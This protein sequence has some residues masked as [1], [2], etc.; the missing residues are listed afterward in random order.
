[1]TFS[2]TYRTLALAT[3]TAAALMLAACTTT[4]PGSKKPWPE[5]AAASE[6]DAPTQVLRKGMPKISP[7]WDPD[8]KKVTVVLTFEVTPEGKMGRKIYK[9]AEA[10]PRIIKAIE[11]SFS[12]WRFKPGTSNGL[13]VST[14]FEQ[15]YDLIFENTQ[16]KPQAKPDLTK[17]DEHTS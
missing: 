3:S 14:C 9:P 1:M 5:C 2:S 10:D 11:R 16:S 13:P 15:P 7:D 6:L 8:G 17:F 12:Q 4:A